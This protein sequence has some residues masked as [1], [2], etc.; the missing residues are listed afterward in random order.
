[1]GPQ[2][3]VFRIILLGG[4]LIVVPVLRYHRIRARA[5]GEHLNRRSEGSLILLTLRP[6]A[7]AAFLALLLY[8]INPRL[9][10]WSGVSLPLW[11]RWVGV[12]GAVTAMVLLFTVLFSLGTNLTDTVVTRARHTLVTTGP[13]RWVRHPFYGAFGLGLASNALITANWFLAVTGFFAF[14]L[15][16]AR[17]RVEEQKLIDRFGEQYTSYMESTG[18]FVPRMLKHRSKPLSPSFDPSFSRTAVAVEQH[19]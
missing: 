13:Y 6:F 8:V 5:S 19:S 7:V 15:V 9:M 17:T 2:E 16:I 4:M 1:M 14:V 18:R 3:Q 12:A 11:L 10:S